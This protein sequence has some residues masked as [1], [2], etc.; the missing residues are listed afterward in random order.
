[1][2]DIKRR[3]RGV[4]VGIEDLA[5]LDALIWFG[6]GEK[7]SQ[8][9]S[10]AQST[11]SRVASRV[12]REF[13]LELV[14]GQG[15][16]LIVGE[17]HYLNQE[18]LLHQSMRMD[19]RAPLRVEAQYYSS[20]VFC[21]KVS[22]NEYQL[23]NFDFLDIQRPIEL[24]RSGV[25][26]AWIAG[27][28]DLPP[29]NDPELAC[30]HLTRLPLRLVVA[31]NHP[32]LAK[33]DEVTLEDVADF[34]CISLRDGAF[35]ESQ[36]ILES[37]GLWNTPTRINRYDQKKW[38]GQTADQVSVGYASV[39]S[40]ELF[41]H[42]MEFLPI[43]L[44]MDVGETLVVRREHEHHPRIQGLLATMKEAA[45]ELAARYPGVRMLF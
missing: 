24:L 28:P 11:I 21:S 15:E 39:F 22:E 4:V 6:S 37:V 35:P 33:G 31:K 16:W 30:I 25:L 40:I 42:P 27:Y 23:G 29:S 26:D 20:P 2:R 32:L 1:M 45:V 7:A 36:R 14:K 3:K 17:T 8:K 19:G 44:G 12:T 13:G 38:L 9:M 5:L 34:P 18:R 41:P 10:V 43:D